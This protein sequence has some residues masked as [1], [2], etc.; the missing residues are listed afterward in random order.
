MSENDFIA[1]LD[2]YEL[3][4]PCDKCGTSTYKPIGW[5][6]CNRHFTCTC[7]AEHSLESEQLAPAIAETARILRQFG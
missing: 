7:G 3:G 2:R 5:I 1:Y 6:K 4:I